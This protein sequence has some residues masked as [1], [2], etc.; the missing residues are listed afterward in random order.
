MQAIAPIAASISTLFGGTA[1]A[2]AGFATAS[3]I[4][5]VVG[6][7]MQLG[8]Q[9]RVSKNAAKV[10]E[11]NAE[12]RSKSTQEAE[13]DMLEQGAEILGE[14]TSAQAASGF[15]LNSPSYRRVRSRAG[16]LAR[17][18]AERTREQASG[19]IENIKQA[20]ADA[21]AEGRGIGPLDILGGVLDIG[22]TMITGA[23]FINTKRAKSINQQ[24]RFNF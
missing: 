18:D 20:A 19:E 23:A 8:Y 17:R 13:K 11:Q 2:A 5:G 12:N 7:L 4:A 22:G 1:E 10:L 9:A 21:R 16:F 6:S 15:S 3:K 14:M 24:A